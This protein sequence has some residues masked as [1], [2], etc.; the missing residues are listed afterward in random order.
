MSDTQHK[1]LC[2]EYH[3]VECS[4]A[5]CRDLFI[6][7]LNVI[8]PSVIMLNVIMLSLIMPRV[9]MLNV[10][11]LNVVM[12]NVIMQNVVMQNVVV[13]NVV[14]QNDIMLNV[15][16]QNVVAPAVSPTFNSS[17]RHLQET[18]VHA[19]YSSQAVPIKLFRNFNRNKISWSVFLGEKKFC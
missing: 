6:V 4:F 14:V 18:V 13:Q 10:V 17:H 5:K 8:V 9:I 1:T 16:M 12:L 11:M 3:Y 19:S 2:I 15:V 7:L